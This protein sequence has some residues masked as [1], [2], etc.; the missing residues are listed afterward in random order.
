MEILG[1]ILGFAII[2]ILNSRKIDMSLCLLA[3]AII[4]AIFTGS[5]VYDMWVFLFENIKDPLTIRLMIIIA[6]ISGLGHLLKENNDLEN[7]IESLYRL[8]SNYRVLSMTIPVMIGTLFVPGG[9][10]LSAPMIEESTGKLGLSASR[11]TALNIFYRHIIFFVYPLYNTIIMTA[12]LYSVSK[13]AI[14]KYNLLITLAG[15]VTAY[16]IFFYKTDKINSNSR[17]NSNKQNGGIKESVINFIQSFSPILSI[18]LISVVFK[19]PF[20]YS[21]FVGL[22][23]GAGHN[24]QGDNKFF[25]Y[26]QRIKNFFTRGIKYKLVFLIFTIM[27]FKLIIEESGQVEVI[28]ELLSASGIPVVVM[29]IFMGIIAGYLTGM[30]IAA[31]GILTPIFIPLLPEGNIIPYISLLYT[32]SFT[33]YIFSPLHLCFVLTKEYFEA[34]LLNTYAYLFIPYV[35][36]I[37]TAILQIVF[38]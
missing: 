7:M 2:I 16:Y 36:M 1:I 35:F 3:G 30:N 27:Y 31:V 21:V 9:A 37:I 8:I 22:L 25:L 23:I 32:A 19:V 5:G 10:I 18:I 11:K 12:E 14:I 38:I 24:L 29:I 34:K 33:G 4:T 26:W 20:Q 28:A 6:V 13:Y 15:L 17:N